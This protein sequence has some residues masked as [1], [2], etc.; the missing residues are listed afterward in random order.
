MKK[1]TSK[2]DRSYKEDRSEEFLEKGLKIY[3]SYPWW[4]LFD[5]SGLYTYRW[6]FRIIPYTRQ[7]LH[8]EKNPIQ[9]VS[10]TQGQEEV[11]ASPES[12]RLAAY[13]YFPWALR[14]ELRLDVDGRYP[15]MTASGSIN[16]GFRFEVHWIANLSK[17]S[18]DTWKGEIWYKHPSTASFPYTHVHIKVENSFFRYNRKAHVIFY[19]PTSKRTRTYD[20]KS[21]H[22]HPMNF[23]YDFA[24]GSH[25]VVSINT[26]IH[27]THP[28]T[29]PAETLTIQEV[30][31]RAGFNVSTIPGAVVPLA[32][33]QADQI[34]NDQEMHDAMQQYW[35]RFVDA[36]QWAI[37]VFF[38][39]SHIG[40]P[41]S[42]GIMFDDIGPN[43]R[44]GTAI[45]LDSTLF[46]AE[47]GMV[48]PLDW[49]ERY[50]FWCAVHEAGHCFNLAHSW[51]KDY[52][53]FGT[54]WIP[55]TNNTASTSFMNYPFRWPNGAGAAGNTETGYFSNFEYRFDD[56][57]LLFMRHAPIEFV[58]PGN[59][60]WFDNHG[61]RGA[62]LVENPPLKLEVRANRKIANFEFMEP[63][64]LELKLTN[65]SS[66]PIVIDEHILSRVDNMIIIAKKDGKPARQ[67]APFAHYDINSKGRV[68]EPGMSEYEALFASVGVN[69]WSLS[70]PG[71]Y[72]VQVCLRFSNMDII[73]LPYRLRIAPPKEH[74]EEWLA[75]DFFSEDVGRI[76]TFDGS[77]V[78]TSGMNTLM[79]VSSRLKDCKVAYHAQIA[80]AKSV[81]VPQKRLEIG[82]AD[83]P[84]MNAGAAG[85]KIVIS[86][87]DSKSAQRDFTKALS[88]KPEQAAE[89]LGHVDFKWYTDHYTDWLE[90][91]GKSAEASAV[92]SAMLKTLKARGVIKTVLD[93]IAD[94][95]DR[96]KKKK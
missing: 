57:E 56:G 27:P 34:W 4:R 95:R 84:F 42:A 26:H 45:F 19:A 88:T 11:T 64:V 23:E 18:R 54:S 22:F 25:P 32:L 14:E 9:P 13:D 91:T 35:S 39:A 7:R 51:Q 16:M 33:A 44:T 38:A 36:P 68:L 12:G 47:A 96:Y 30:Y 61:F 5:V 73:S 66:Q 86:K 77:Q 82:K 24:E 93:D 80:L 67:F 81:A 46:D 1:K 37:W 28:S 48:Q 40:G 59:A 74:E 43:H 21:P 69:G 10:Q 6:D 15:Q 60:D 79:D 72:T 75:Q 92:Q 71:Y 83:Q 90:K 87:P 65:I 29:I 50:K 94:R 76:L 55:L 41:G 49:E 20:F 52:P 70:E 89:S 85:G 2:P 8:Y 63:V 78:L 58:Q 17:V 62:N 3:E 31:R 53:W